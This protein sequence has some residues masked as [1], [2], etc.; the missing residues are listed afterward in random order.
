[1]NVRITSFVF[2]KDYLEMINKLKTVN[3]DLAQ[4]FLNSI[5]EYGIYGKYEDNGNIMLQTLMNPIMVRIDGEVNKYLSKLPKGNKQMSYGPQVYYFSKKPKSYHFLLND[6]EYIK[7]RNPKDTKTEYSTIEQ[8]IEAYY[9]ELE[10]SGV[11]A[12]MCGNVCL[13]IGSTRNFSSR[14]HEHVK[15][16]M[17]PGE[18]EQKYEILRYLLHNNYEIRVEILNNST[19]EAEYKEKEGN[20]IHEKKPLL[21]TIYPKTEKYAAKKIELEYNAQEIE[22]IIKNNSI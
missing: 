17:E 1:M 8:L 2:H 14:I 7:S 21:N 16:I 15:A 11:Y 10:Q 18:K 9:P 4:Q 22:E 5:V 20:F 6:F 12:F 3:P 13:Y 19:D